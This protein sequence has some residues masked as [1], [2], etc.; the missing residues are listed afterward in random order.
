ML[1]FIY[2]SVNYCLIEKFLKF[3]LISISLTFSNS[4]I[5]IDCSS[6]YWSLLLGSAKK[7]VSSIPLTIV[8]LVLNVSSSKLEIQNIYIPVY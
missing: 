8:I 7:S 4:R 2:S 5:S 1:E 6:C 3:E